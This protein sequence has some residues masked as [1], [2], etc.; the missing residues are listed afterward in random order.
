[1]NLGCATGH[2]SFV[3]S[4]ELHEP[5]DRPARPVGEPEQ[6]EIRQQR[7]YAAEGAGREGRAAA[8]GEARCEPHRA[9]QEAGRLHRRAGGRAVQGRALPVLRSNGNWQSIQNAPGPKDGPGAF[10]FVA[11]DGVSTPPCGRGYTRGARSRR[12]RRVRRRRGKGRR[13]PG[14]A[15]PRAPRRH[16]PAPRHRTR[17]RRTRRRGGPPSRRRPPR[18]SWADARRNSCRWPCHARRLPAPSCGTNRSPCTAC[19]RRICR[20]RSRGACP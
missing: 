6:R 17:W 4:N 12:R 16:R 7:L 11:N 3:M 15:R 2:P 8:P 5:D 1:V 19:R 18:A 10:C 13:A 20:A 9:F 14:V